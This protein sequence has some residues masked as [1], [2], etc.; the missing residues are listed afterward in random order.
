MRQMLQAPGDAVFILGKQGVDL[1]VLG[2]CDGGQQARP[3]GHGCAG[4]RR[5][6]EGV[7]DRPA[8]GASVTGAEFDLVLDRARVLLVVGIAGVDGDAHGSGTGRRGV[9]HVG[10]SQATLGRGR[11]VLIGM[12]ARKGLDQAQ[13]FGRDVVGL[14]LGM[15]RGPHD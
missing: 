3:I 9:G 13:Q 6:Q 5:V 8:L 12:G 14:G 10:R 1:A 2:R 11:I 7:D 15:R 4:D